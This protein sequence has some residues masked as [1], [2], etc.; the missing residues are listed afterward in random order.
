[1]LHRSLRL[2]CA[3]KNFLPFTYLLSSHNADFGL[4]LKLALK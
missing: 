2:L 3:N 1:M 4:T